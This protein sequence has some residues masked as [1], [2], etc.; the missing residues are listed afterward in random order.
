MS[1]NTPLWAPTEDQVA[2][3]S[4]TKFRDFCAVRNAVELPGH[5]AFHQWSIDSRG[6]FW[7]AVWDFCQVR[8]EKGGRDLVNGDVMLDAR[9]FPDVRLNFAENLLVKH[10]P[11]GC[12]DLPRRG[13]GELPLELGPASLHRLKA[14]AGLPRL[15]H[16]Q[17]RPHLGDDAEHA[18]NHRVHAGSKLDR[19]RLAVLL[20]RFRR[21][22]RA[23]SLRPD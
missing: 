21:A 22:G 16:R 11:E 2:S 19:R 7:S 13:Q 4:I 6:P 20:A 17:G 10:G 8:G 1:E 23:R 15:G 9:F 12:I 5:D 3:S 18:G 14:A